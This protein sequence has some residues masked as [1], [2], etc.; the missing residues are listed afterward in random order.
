MGSV[1]DDTKDMFGIL[2]EILRDV[3]T[4]APTSDKKRRNRWGNSTR[5]KRITD[6]VKRKFNYSCCKCGSKDN[7]E[8][9]H[10]KS[11]RDNPELSFSGDNMLLLCNGCHRSLH[12]FVQNKQ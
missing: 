12:G 1:E 2:A 8:I 4:N 5:R 11:I 7:L 9:H 3:A 6:G 10:I